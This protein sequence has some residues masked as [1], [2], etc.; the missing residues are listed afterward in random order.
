LDTGII[1]RAISGTYDVK[2]DRRPLDA[3]SA[4]SG[5]VV[6]KPRG[7]F[8]KLGITPLV[9]DRVT[10]S[11]TTI[12]EVLPRR[13]QFIRPPVANAEVMVMVASESIPVT[14]TFVLDT[15]IAFAET[16]YAEPVIVINKT[17]IAPADELYR[18]YCSAGFAVVRASVVT[19]R[20]V[21]ELSAA[22]SGKICAFAGDTGVGKS[23][24][25]N[26]IA[27]LSGADEIKLSVGDVSS[28][29]GRG[30]HTTRTTQLFELGGDTML[31]DAAG[32][33][34]VEE[35]IIPFDG[36]ENAFRE[37]APYSGA[38]RFADCRHL[39]E[40]DCAVREA[41]S[42]GAIAKSRYASYVRLMELALDRE[43]NKWK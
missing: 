18:V 15:L 8:R 34:A 16:N 17:D 36:L 37:I 35:I 4:G 1:V 11:G 39:K 19:G 28:K 29:L 7:V 38:C 20:G 31:I 25:I 23:S 10:I 9:G 43:A 14:D 5:V 3:D 24:I 41:V 13:N 12:Q 30:R 26:A 33:A 42:S 27:G 21:A 40:P 32:F 22:L 6:C 2:I